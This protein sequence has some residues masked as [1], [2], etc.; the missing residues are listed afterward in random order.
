[1]NADQQSLSAPLFTDE[2]IVDRLP[3][4]MMVDVDRERQFAA[5][6]ELHGPFR[7]ITGSRERRGPDRRAGARQGAEPRDGFKEGHTPRICRDPAG[8]WVAIAQILCSDD[9]TRLSAVGIKVPKRR[10]K[11]IVLNRRAEQCLWAI[12]SQVLGQRSST[13][14]LPDLALGQFV[15]GVDSTT[16]PTNWRQELFKSLWSLSKVNLYSLRRSDNGSYEIGS[17]SVLVGSVEDRRLERPSEDKCDEHCVLLNNPQKHHHFR[18]QIGLGFLGVLENFHIASES[19]NRDY[20]FDPD[21]ATDA[22]VEARRTGRIIPVS[23]PLKLLGTAHRSP[24]SRPQQRLL[25]AMIRET[26]RAPR[27]SRPGR[28]AVFHGDNVV[29]AKIG[30]FARCPALVADDDYIAFGGNGR[31]RGMGYR[32]VGQHDR[33]WLFKCGY[34]LPNSDGALSAEVRRFVRDLADVSDRL[35]L[36]PVGFE[37]KS[38]TWVEFDTIKRLAEGNNGWHHVDDL[39]LRIYAPTDIH[40]RLREM[41]TE[42][43]RPSSDPYSVQPPNR[44]VRDRRRRKGEEPIGRLLARA[45]IGQTALALRLGVSQAFVSQLLSGKKRWPEEKERV[46]RQFAA[47]VLAKRNKSNRCAERRGSRVRSRSN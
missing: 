9:G 36:T 45:G 26:T 22:V 42:S 44:Y 20:D 29:G 8:K 15:W 6:G 13:V 33:G 38:A 31:R 28:A 12:H 39:H 5:I 25:S 18:V 30:D 11:T 19:E 7:G 32:I 1:M 35:Q 24:L 17:A 4:L 10:R 21:D 41:L 46:A 14:T 43:P 34:Q 23:G 40:D 3:P 37:P 16:W 47:S 27:S 2:P